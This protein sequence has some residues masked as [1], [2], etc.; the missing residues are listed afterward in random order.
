MY[1]CMCSLIGILEKVVSFMALLS[2]SYTDTVVRVTG[3]GVSSYVVMFAFIFFS[4]LLP[5]YLISCLRAQMSYCRPLPMY[6]TNYLPSSS[7]I[8]SFSLPSVT[9]YTKYSRNKIKHLFSCLS[10][11]MY[12]RGSTCMMQTQGHLRRSLGKGRRAIA[13]ANRFFMGC[14]VICVCVCLCLCGISVIVVQLPGV[15]VARALLPTVPNLPS[16]HTCFAN[17]V[18]HCSI[19]IE[20]Q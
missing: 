19:L 11:S 5:F 1:V 17:L 9:E 15:V 12:P 4:C 10:S 14:I 2:S 13:S 7:A 16:L 8:D 6:L 20:L 3:Y 18:C